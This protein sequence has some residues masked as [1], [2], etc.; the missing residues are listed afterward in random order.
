MFAKFTTRL[1]LRRIVRK[2]QKQRDLMKRELGLENQSEHGR[3]ADLVRDPQ[4][5]TRIYANGV[6]TGKI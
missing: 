2:L 5:V 3:N 4:Y 1:K 6:E